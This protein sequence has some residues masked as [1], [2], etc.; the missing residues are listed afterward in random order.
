MNDS[1]ALARAFLCQQLELGMPDI[2][3]PPGSP[4]ATARTLL[5]R[6]PEGNLSPAP[7]AGMIAPKPPLPAAKPGEK[8]RL[9]PVSRLMAA[10][11]KQPAVSDD[12]MRN[13]LV[14]LYSAEKDCAACGLSARRKTFVFG[15]GNVHAPLMIVGEAP[16]AEEDAQG[17]PFVGAAG[18]L[19][20]AMLGAI[21]LDR[22]KD[23]FIANVLKCRPP[24]NRTPEAGEIAACKRLLTAQVNIMRPRVFLLLGRIAAH[25]LFDTTDS[26]AS[27]RKEV[28]SVNGVPAVVTYHPAAMLRNPEYKRPAWEDMQKLRTLLTELG[29]YAATT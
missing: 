12:P 23:V 7:A 18:E 11:A 16:G 27:L 1:T 17:V 10:P 24:A 15:S 8:P 20:T 2:I 29:A 21:G 3:L 22:K 5:A 19:L 9:L 4:A 13:A 14:A 6:R 28:R 26:I 25:T